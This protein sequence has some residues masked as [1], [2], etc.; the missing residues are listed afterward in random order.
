MADFMIDRN[1]AFVEGKQAAVSG[2]TY[3]DN[4]HARGFT[5]LGAIKPSEETR[6]LFD[7]WANGFGSIGR[8][9]TPQ[10]VADALRYDPSQF[11][12]KSNRYYNS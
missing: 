4:P 2:K 7:A 9:A 6:E 8:R 11:K 12:R 10:E 5:K 1:N 3:N